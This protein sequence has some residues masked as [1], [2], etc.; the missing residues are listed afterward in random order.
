MTTNGDGSLT[1]PVE[2]QSRYEVMEMHL[3]DENA[4]REEAL[5][6]AGTSAVNRRGVR[7]YLCERLAK[8]DVGTVCEGCKAQAIPFAQTIAQ[9]LEAEGLLDEADKYRRL[10]EKLLKETGQDRSGD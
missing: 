7:G 9:D 4:R 6:G 8:I 1:R 2:A 5:C 3:F 10:Y